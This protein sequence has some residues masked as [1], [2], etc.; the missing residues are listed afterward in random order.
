MVNG[1]RE[2]TPLEAIEWIRRLEGLGAGEILLT[3]MDRDGTGEGYDL[4]LLRAASAAVS[5]PGDR[6]GR[7]RP[8][9]APG[10]G[11]RGRRARRPRGHHL[12]LPGLHAPRGAGLPAASAATRCARDRRCC[13][14]ALAA[15]APCVRLTRAGTQVQ[16][17][18]RDLPGP[19]SDRRPDRARRR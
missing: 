14:L 1:G 4:P 12:P 13:L 15:A 16:G 18:V 10:R 2:A 5:I 7:R 9:R 8:A 17:D 11:V 6:L 3:S 19:L